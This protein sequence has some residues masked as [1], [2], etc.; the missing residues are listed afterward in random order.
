MN[1]LAANRILWNN[2]EE[3]A[4]LRVGRGVWWIVDGI[5]TP[6]VVVH[7]NDQTGMVTIRPGDNPEA[8]FVVPLVDVVDNVM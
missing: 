6:H 7:V 3:H 1:F 2:I 5:D 8:E 4:V